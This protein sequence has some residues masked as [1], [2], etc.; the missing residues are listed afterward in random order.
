LSNAR[1]IAITGATGFLGGHV[2]RALLAQGLPVRALV[3]DIAR[4]QALGDIDLI[5]GDLN[6]QKA[7]EQ[8]VQGSQAV[9][10]IA[11][12][13][14]ARTPQQLIAIN[15]GGTQNLVDA[16]ARV[17]PEIRLVHVSSVTARE[18]QLSAYAKS[19][20]ASEHAA[21]THG[22]PVVI[23]RPNAI[24]GPGDRET[25]Q[26]FEVAGGSLHPLLGGPEA[27][28]AMIH[29]ADAASAILAMTDLGAPVGLFEICD[30]RTQGY[31]WREITETAVAA[32][33]GTYRPIKVPAG[34][35]KLAG[36]LSGW[37]GKYQKQPPIFDSGKVNEILH[38]DWGV[39]PSR[40]IPS[41]IW[42]PKI[43]LQQG[44]TE[45]VHWYRQQGWLK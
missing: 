13:I 34:L 10:H 30:E 33:G 12:A 45:T 44:F 17:N 28:I 39:H 27:R 6:N 3:R 21:H 1:P 37:L 35:L 36:S 43:N 29:G 8:L 18:P 16:C 9:I 40:L 25:L 14:K 15:G 26:V 42:K 22:G 2:V 4:G 31:G 7:L 24:Y 20:A 19:K 23:V 5:E 32:V 38:G 11:G 41:E